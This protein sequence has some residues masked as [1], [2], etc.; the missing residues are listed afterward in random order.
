MELPPDVTFVGSSVALQR[1]GNVLRLEP[2][3]INTKGKL[4]FTIGLRI[5][6]DADDRFTFHT[7]LDDFD[8][9]CEATDALT[10]RVFSDKSEYG[11]YEA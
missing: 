9:Y 5:N 3:A 6:D 10:V 1:D 4:D 2:L 7:F 11:F 8:A